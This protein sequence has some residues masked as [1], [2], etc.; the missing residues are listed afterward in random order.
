M[1]RAG[2]EAGAWRIGTETRV[3]VSPSR[4][5]SPSPPRGWAVPARHGPG[6][7]ERPRGHRGIVPGR[8]PRARIVAANRRCQ[9]QQVVV[10]AVHPQRSLLRTQ[11]LHALLEDALCRFLQ[12]EDRRQ[13]LADGEKEPDLVPPLRQLPSRAAI[14]PASSQVRSSAARRTSATGAAFPCA[15]TCTSSGGPPAGVTRKRRPAAVGGPLAPA[16]KTGI[17]S[18]PTAC[19]ARISS[20]RPARKS[21]SIPP[22]LSGSGGREAA[23]RVMGRRGF[24]PEGQA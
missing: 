18:P 3:S 19:Q 13:R 8:D 9:T 21:S 22:T 6:R 1:V 10:R 24:L 20:P 17:R 12:I 16:G 11:H 4:S 7:P 14:R 5:P 23:S 15:S 2:P